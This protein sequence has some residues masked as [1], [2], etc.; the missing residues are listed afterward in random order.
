MDVRY[1]VHSAIVERVN[2]PVTLKSGRESMALVHGMTVELVEV[3]GHN[4]I[5]RRFVPEDMEAAEAMFVPGSD[6]IVT[7]T[8]AA[9]VEPVA[10]PAEE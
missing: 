6:V 4:T 3:G 2:Q 8:P 10:A 5:T 7:F 1:A 9:P